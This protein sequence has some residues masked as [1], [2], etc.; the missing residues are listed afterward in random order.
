VVLNRGAKAIGK[1]LAMLRLSELGAEVATVR[2]GKSRIEVTPETV[3]Q[4]GDIVVL[5]GATEGVARAEARLF[6]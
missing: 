1:S 4:E 2:R 3:L 6:V 5:R